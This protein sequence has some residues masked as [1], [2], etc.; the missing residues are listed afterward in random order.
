MLMIPF[1]QTMYRTFVQCRQIK[2]NYTMVITFSLPFEVNTFGKYFVAFVWTHTSLLTIAI[3]KVTVSP[4]M[5]TLCFHIVAEMK[6]LQ[7]ILTEPNDVG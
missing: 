6:N 5:F 3:T 7:L 1:F 4:I 2:S